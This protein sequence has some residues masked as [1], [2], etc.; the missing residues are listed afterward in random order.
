MESIN[1]L[2]LLQKAHWWQILCIDDDKTKIP[3]KH[4]TMGGKESLKSWAPYNPV[5]QAGVNF[6]YM[7]SVCFLMTFA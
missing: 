5:F 3:L 1:K 4:S 6:W 7:R 2:Q